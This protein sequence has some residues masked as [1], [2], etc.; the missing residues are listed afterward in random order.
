TQCKKSKISCGKLASSRAWIIDNNRCCPIHAN[1]SRG[2][3][4]V[5]HDPQDV[6]KEQVFGRPKNSREA[7]LLFFCHGRKGRKNGLTQWHLPIGL[8]TVVKSRLCVLSN[9]QAKTT[10]SARYTMLVEGL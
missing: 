5:P 1:A 6:L 4:A 8:R 7:L 2:I 9:G 3:L 10:N